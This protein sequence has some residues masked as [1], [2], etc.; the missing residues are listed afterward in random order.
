MEFILFFGLVGMVVW[1]FNLA[2]R[3][4]RLDALMTYLRKQHK[5][6]KKTS[7]QKK[8]DKPKEAK[9]STPP[10]N[11]QE[12]DFFPWESTTIKAKNTL[13]PSVASIKK[14][15]E[16]AFHLESFLGGQL[17]AIL[18]ALSLVLT[19]G[20]FTEYAFSSAMIGPKGRI[21]IGILY[22]LIILGIGEFLRPRYPSFFD[23][24][25]ATGIAGLLV[26]VY[27]A[28]NYDFPTLENPILTSQQAFWSYFSIIGVGIGLSL[29][30]NS[31]F[32]AS[33]TIIAG[34]L[35]PMGVNG[36]DNPVGLLAYL[37]L[38]AGAGFTISLYKK[39]PEILGFLFM[40]IMAYLIGIFIMMTESKHNWDQI[41][42][43]LFL[44]FTYGLSILLGSGGI[45]RNL[46]TKNTSSPTLTT[47]DTF[48][49]L[50]FIAAIFIAN[51][52]GYNVFDNQSWDHFGFFVLA[53]GFGFFFLS[54][55]FKHKKLDIFQKI[56]LS[57]TL[58][59][60][61]FATIWEIGSEKSFI[62]TLL[63][64]IEGALFCFA[65]RATNELIFKVFSRIAIMMA[66]IYV[67][68]IESFLES[69]ISIIA[70]IAVT[71]YTLSEAKYVWQKIWA[72]IGII[73]TSS[74]ILFWSFDRLPK[75]INTDFP[76]FIIPVIWAVG[77][78]Y[79]VLITRNNYS[80]IAGVIFIG[81]TSLL[82]WSRFDHNQLIDSQLIL[83]LLLGGKALIL[84]TFFLDEK[85]LRPEP[86]VQRVATIILLGLATATVLIFGAE[87][88][89]EPTRTIFWMFWGGFLFSLGQI[90]SWTHFRYFGM[91]IFIA[92]I[93]K[94]YLI[95]LWGWDGPTRILAFFALGLALLSI[96]LIYHKKE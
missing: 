82:A 10:T 72:A 93:A 49:V 56:A 83:A 15:P 18:G 62:L 54:E 23:K 53:Q 60:I 92:I 24:I 88:L 6:N 91:G 69:T 26:T 36:N 19:V 43:L 57:A 44:T 27:L 7:T 45:I 35:M 67:F 55:L 95:D 84:T 13:K 71:F 2:S 21:A 90:K 63:L 16:K 79:S 51:I 12:D 37:S 8:P 87:N 17:F 50:L 78:A 28:R 68:Q 80:R 39:W 47:I 42:P 58:I 32:L 75:L 25:S 22:A 74:E 85:G 61:I 77:L 59:S 76:S 4:D 66:F 9:V 3:I 11:I 41:T 81:I 52:H 33:F 29:Q 89:N 20:F 64:S 48:E 94:L 30:Y 86:I 40:G 96:S 46:M 5:L 34:I 14:T 38:L 31:R 73:L 65:G 70:T 1:N